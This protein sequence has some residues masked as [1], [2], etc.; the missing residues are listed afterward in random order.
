MPGLTRGEAE[1]QAVIKTQMAQERLNQLQIRGQQAL[2]TTSKL[3]QQVAAMAAS[4]FSVMGA[5]RLVRT[6]VDVSAQFEL[7]KV[8]LGAILQSTEKA[9]EMYEKI[10]D[11]AVQSPFN[12]KELMTYAKQLTAFSVPVGELYN[13]TKMLADVS[14]GLGVGM[15]RLVLAYGQIRSASFLRGLSFSG[16]SASKGV[17]NTNSLNCWNISPETISSQARAAA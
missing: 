4:Y 7:Q 6:L 12:F 5:T 14:A 1:A 17:K 16:L 9:A 11:L 15:D 2:K 10:K 8:T 13:T 3:W